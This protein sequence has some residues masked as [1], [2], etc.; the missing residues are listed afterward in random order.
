MKQS[1][2]L[3]S[4]GLTRKPT[5]GLTRAATRRMY[6]LHDLIQSRRY[7]NCKTL[8]DALEISPKTVQRD[9]NTMRD[10]LMLPVEYHP[11]EHGY[12][13]TKPVTQFPLLH[14]SRS[15]LIS[16]FLARKAL[17]PIRGTRLEKV[18]AHS[19]EKITDACPGSVTFHW[20][21]LDSAFSVKT[22]GALETDLGLFG[23]LLDATMNS[24]EITFDY[25][26]L[27]DSQP[28]QRHVRPYHVGQLDHGWYVI[29]FDL[30][31]KEMRTFALQ[32]I[33]GL[34]V[35]KTKFQMPVDF[36][37]KKYLSSSFGVWAYGGNEGKPQPIRVRFEGYA[38]RII[39]ERLW[40]PTQEIILLNQDGSEV[41]LRM[42]IAGLEEITRWIL[43]WGSK[44][45]VISPAKLKERV[46]QEAAAVAGKADMQ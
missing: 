7:P 14:L 11:V 31:R 16:L 32:R 21:E 34:T 39:S 24:V 41:E 13:Y 43:S 8:A 29:G 10:D 5:K 23:Q 3:F 36:D 30:V 2:A 6:L 18:L 38:A 1:H 42:T 19:F 25:R 45:R 40:H 37:V 20:H 27:S 15:D 4:S 17:E 28:E 12:Y 9:V 33:A 26:K 35:S 22:A 44:A 46:Q